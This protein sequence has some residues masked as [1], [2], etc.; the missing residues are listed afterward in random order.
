MKA[1]AILALVLLA[2]VV[3]SWLAALI[4]ADLKDRGRPSQDRSG[5]GLVI[6]T[7]IAA[8]LLCILSIGPARTPAPAPAGDP[9]NGHIAGAPTDQVVAIFRM[10]L[11]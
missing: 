11:N 10:P 7:A 2:L 9:E 3:G 6:A 1:F 5:K 4:R 8:V